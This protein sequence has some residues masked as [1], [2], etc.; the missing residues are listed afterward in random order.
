[1]SS[2]AVIKVFAV[3]PVAGCILGSQEYTTQFESLCKYASYAKYVKELTLFPK[4][5]YL[6]EVIRDKVILWNLINCRDLYFY[7]EAYKQ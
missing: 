7:F 4:Q 1:M 5:D 2:Y 6:Y 3:R